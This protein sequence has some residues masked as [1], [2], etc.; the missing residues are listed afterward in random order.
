M[1]SG[2]MFRWQASLWMILHWMF[3]V[4]FNSCCALLQQTFCHAV[5]GYAL[6]FHHFSMYSACLILH[7]I[8]VWWSSDCVFPHPALPSI[9]HGI[10]PTRSS[11]GSMSGWMAELA[12][13]VDA[14]QTGAQAPPVLRPRPSC[15]QP[16]MIESSFSVIVSHSFV[17][18]HHIFVIQFGLPNR[19]HQSV[20]INACGISFQ[21]RQ[22]CGIAHSQKSRQEVENTVGAGQVQPKTCVTMKTPQNSTKPWLLKEELHWNTRQSLWDLIEI[23]WFLRVGHQ[24][25]QV[26]NSLSQE[27]AASQPRLSSFQT[28]EIP[29]ELVGRVLWKQMFLLSYHVFVELFSLFNNEQNRVSKFAG[30][31]CIAGGNPTALLTCAVQLIFTW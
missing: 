6:V 25:L 16:F 19:C 9:L 26:G 1:V 17:A 15:K 22:A 13:L 29:P 11:L 14:A 28:L 20:T 7:S 5:T 8:A 2:C 24:L 30:T 10:F 23:C 12:D 21:S 31:Y 3:N 18:L 4:Q 27:V